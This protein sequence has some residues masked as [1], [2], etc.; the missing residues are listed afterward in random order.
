M[1]EFHNRPQ[2]GCYK[3]AAGKICW[4]YN[5]SHVGEGTFAALVRSDLEQLDRLRAVLQ[6]VEWVFDSNAGGDWC[7]SCL[8]EKSQGHYDCPIDKALHGSEK[9]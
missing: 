8:C 3:D 9:P 5:G 6:S 2:T 4:V 7:P 1:M